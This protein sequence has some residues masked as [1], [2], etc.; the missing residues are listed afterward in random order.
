M[1]SKFR[2]LFPILAIVVLA[3]TLTIAMVLSEKQAHHTMYKIIAQDN[4][5]YYTDSY[6]EKDGCIT[7]TQENHNIPLTQN[8]SYTI[9]LCGN[10]TIIQQSSAK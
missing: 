7:F 10:F 8:N 2:I 5:Y 4:Q 3:I 1:I 6:D 9:T